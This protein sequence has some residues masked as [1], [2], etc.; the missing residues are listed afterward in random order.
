MYTYIYTYTFLAVVGGL[1]HSISKMSYRLPLRGTR[2]YAF[3]RAPLTRFFAD[4]FPSSFL[5]AGPSCTDRKTVR[6]SK[7]K[8]LI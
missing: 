4:F 7:M 6:L 1:P 5:G 8:S 2:F 3:I